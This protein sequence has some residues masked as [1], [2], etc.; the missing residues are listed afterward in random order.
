M[1]VPS[2]HKGWSKCGESP[3]VGTCRGSFLERECGE[4]P[5]KSGDR[6]DQAWC[7]LDLGL[8]VP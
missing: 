3:Q 1:P 5:W 6:L 2:K 7:W 8:H 4:A